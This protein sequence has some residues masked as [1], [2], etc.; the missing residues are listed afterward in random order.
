[1]SE[2]RSAPAAREA[3]NIRTV[4]ACANCEHRRGWLDNMR[5]ALLENKDGDNCGVLP[6]QIC[7]KY[8][9]VK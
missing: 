9:V 1:M 5:C 4:D 3:L 8:E 6:Y 2:E 7:D